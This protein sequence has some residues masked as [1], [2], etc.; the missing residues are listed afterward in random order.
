[1]K[2]G[3]AELSIG[4]ENN[5]YENVKHSVLAQD[6][7]YGWSFSSATVTIGCGD[8][9]YRTTSSVVH[10]A[11]HLPY[12]IIPKGMLHSIITAAY[13]DAVEKEL[14]TRGLNCNIDSHTLLIVCNTVDQS[15]D[16]F[17]GLK[18]EVE[19]TGL[20]FDVPAKD[21]VEFVVSSLSIP[22]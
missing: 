20:T 7:L 12:L 19:A 15:I 17:P 18:L 2:A 10:C 22:P 9:S 13:N 16:K 5:D 11:T 6:S 3:E 4:S 8:M 1:M 14:Q 21:L